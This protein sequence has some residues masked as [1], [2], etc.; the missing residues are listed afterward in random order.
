MTGAY[1][2]HITLKNMSLI[3]FFIVLF[4]LTIKC[5]SL[6]SH[7]GILI[8][9]FYIIFSVIIFIIVFIKSKKNNYIKKMLP[10]LI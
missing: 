8:L 1:P 10:S 6:F 3:M 2:K 9:I 7:Y 5:L 4:F